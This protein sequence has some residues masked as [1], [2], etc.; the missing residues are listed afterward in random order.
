M[1]AQAPGDSRDFPL[2]IVRRLDHDMAIRGAKR[3]EIALRIDHHLLHLPGR[4]LQQAAQ[5]V[6][7]SRPGIALNKQSGGQQFL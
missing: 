7:L 2:G 6:R 1:F 4:P 3:D 5:Q